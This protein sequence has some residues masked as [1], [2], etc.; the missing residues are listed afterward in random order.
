MQ[1]WVYL[2]IWDYITAVN[3]HGMFSNRGLINIY[4]M[5]LHALYWM[6][7]FAD[8]C[9]SLRI[10][11]V[12]II[13][14]NKWCCFMLRAEDSIVVKENVYIGYYIYY[15]VEMK[16]LCLYISKVLIFYLPNSVINWIMYEIDIISTYYTCMMKKVTIIKLK[17]IYIYYISKIKTS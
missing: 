11:S 3:V 4:A 8:F 5:H 12:Y 13:Y 7:E 9:N 2:A 14:K 6:S 15:Y 17:V 10:V 1:P 16:L